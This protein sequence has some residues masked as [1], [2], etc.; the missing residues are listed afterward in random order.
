VV[1]EKFR[2]EGEMIPDHTRGSK[3]VGTTRTGWFDTNA[4]DQT[5]EVL[6]CEDQNRR[7]KNEIQ[8]LSFNQTLFAVL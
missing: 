3:S 2:P 6:A 1:L 5:Q 8:E 7:M 4:G